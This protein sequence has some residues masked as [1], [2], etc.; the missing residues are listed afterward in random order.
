MKNKKNFYIV[1]FYLNG[2]VY[3]ALSIKK[4]DAVQF[5]EFFENAHENKAG[6]T[7]LW[8]RVDIDPECKKNS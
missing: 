1:R 8:F 3:S 7:T 5:R 2:K 6:G 4:K